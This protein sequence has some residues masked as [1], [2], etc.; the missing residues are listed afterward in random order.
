[1]ASPVET[2]PLHEAT[3]ERYLSYALSVITSRA[4]PD[5][6][7]GLKPVQRRI[8]YTMY[9]DMN[10]V[11]NG[12]YSKCAA[13][14]G[15]VMGKY[16]PHGDSSIYEA[17]VRMAQDFSLLAP[18]VDGQGNFG[19]LDGDPP[20]AHR[21]TECKLRPMALEL[22]TE[23]R[24]RTVDYRPN[25]DG[26]RFEPVVLPA[27][28]PQLLVNGCEGI[29]VG[30]ATRVPPHNLAEV[31][32]AAVALIDDRDLP[33]SSLL[34]HV[35]GPDFPTGGHLLAT[36]AELR[37]IYETGQGTLKVR[38]TFEQDKDG[39]RRQLVVTSV[40]YG[41]NKARIV[42]E[43]GEQVRLKKL[44]QVTDV[45]DESTDV[46]RIVLE[47]K[48][49][50]SPEQVMAWLFKHTQLQ[51]TWP[52]N[53][54]ALVPT[55]QDDGT[56]GV[57]TP[58]RLDLRAILLHWLD[59]RFETLRRRYQFDLEELRKRI[60]VLEG[61]EKLFDALDEA[62][63]LIRSSEGKTDAAE[64][65]IA[66]FD[67]TDVQV[68]AI[69][70]LRLYKLARLEIQAI[71]EEL[72]EL[73]Q[74]A[75]RIEK[76]LASD[77]RLWGEVRKELLEVRKVH[78]APRRTMVGVPKVDV[79]YDEDAYIVK[80]DA[81]VVVTR[82]GWVKRQTTVSDL[83][84]VRVREGDEVGWLVKA[85][86]RSTLT[87]FTTHGSAYVLR[88]GDVEQTTGYGSPLQAHFSF[89]DGERVVGVI[90]H[91]ARHRPLLQESLPLAADEPPPPW[92]VAMT[93]RG[94][95]LR[96][97]TR[98]HEEPSTRAGR[99][100][101]KL[102][103]DD[104]VFAVWPMRADTDRV[105]VASR[106]GRA[107]VFPASEV[108]VLRAAGKG[109]TGLKLKPD[110][111]LVAFELASGPMEGP[112]V[113]TSFGRELEVRERKFGLSAR[114]SRGK[115]VLVRGSIEAWRRGPAVWTGEEAP[116][117][118][119]RAAA[120]PVPAARDDAAPAPGADAIEE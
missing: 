18:L 13:V 10:L 49:D 40:P 67:L 111:E 36:D 19:S 16:H 34:A 7:D 89:A 66:R 21:Y 75:Q 23:I 70:E 102:D 90:S 112:V 8:L 107:S 60:H 120:E 93:A 117:P 47:L 68:D 57:P 96:F 55:R 46:V 77:R 27:Q 97:P 5:V 17:L 32:D 56:P 69:L 31:V 3:A 118:E 74:E 58:S 59:F 83:A 37:S 76:L 6:R 15:E 38:G 30:M 42:E 82:E 11:P 87:I 104:Q 71:R 29:A 95:V 100:F 106:G 110:D 63:A 12:R 14:V 88:V 9:V 92:A 52:V 35:R 54:T 103:D 119:P 61:F 39:R 78:A 22:L 44:P 101:A 51:S 86:T 109:V 48:Q 64:R 105:C 116:K 2:V 65:L 108:A 1:M 26:Q 25:Y 114:G 20:A 43:I 41:T 4:L 33:V 28:F 50:A 73:R 53:L 99:R 113:V 98:P 24:K 85:H 84:K 81:F 62:I 45:R 80:E 94:R 72:A 91:D 79:A 115:V